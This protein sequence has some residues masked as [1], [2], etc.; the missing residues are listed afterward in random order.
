M[1]KLNCVDEIRGV[2]A[3]LTCSFKLVPTLLLCLLAEALSKLLN[4]KM[5]AFSILLIV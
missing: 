1:A 3:T 4:V 5:F 2:Y